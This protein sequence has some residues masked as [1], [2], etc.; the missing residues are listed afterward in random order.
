MKCDRV[1]LSFDPVPPFMFLF[2]GLGLSLCWSG[3]RRS[4]I[5]PKEVRH[6]SLPLG[7]QD[8]KLPPSQ[9]LLTLSVPLPRTRHATLAPGIS[10]SSSSLSSPPPAV[11]QTRTPRPSRSLRLCVPGLPFYSKPQL[12]RHGRGSFK[13]VA[14]LLHSGIL[15]EYS[16]SVA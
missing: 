14:P 7:L 8:H 6:W 13:P 1:Y 9:L 5:K 16:G 12:G 10:R 4:I 15:G 3:G 11:S 2:L